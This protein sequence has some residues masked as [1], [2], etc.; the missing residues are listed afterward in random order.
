MAR[1]YFNLRH[2][3][4]LFADPVGAD[5]AGLAV[6]QKG[7]S[8][9]A[10]DLILDHPLESNWSRCR[11]EIMDADGELVGLIPFAELAGA[12]Y[13]ARPRLRCLSA[14]ALAV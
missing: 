6:A 1:F 11:F 3:A 7:A 12:S 10:R 8:E 2:G 4:Y 9:A 5:Y 13:K 14:P